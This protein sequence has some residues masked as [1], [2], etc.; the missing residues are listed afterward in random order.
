MKKRHVRLLALLIC[1]VMLCSLVPAKA[2]A[3]ALQGKKMPQMQTITYNEN[4]QMHIITEFAD[5][6]H[7]AASATQIGFNRIPEIIQQIQRYKSLH[8][9]GKAA[10]VNAASTL[11]LQ[12]LLC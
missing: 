7:M 1:A 4:W 9:S 2:N 3:V 6:Q 12:E 10:T 8:R 5:L 11:A